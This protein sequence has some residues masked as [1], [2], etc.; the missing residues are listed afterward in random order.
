MK[1]LQDLLANTVLIE[2]KFHINGSFRK[3]LAVT[4]LWHLNLDKAKSET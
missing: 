3:G 1:G 2:T 4:L